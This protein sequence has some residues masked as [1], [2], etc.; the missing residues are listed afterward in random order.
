MAEMN[1]YRKRELQ[2][3]AQEYFS[4]AEKIFSD[5]RIKESR[6]GKKIDT[7]VLE[8]A[9]K[10]IDKGLEIWIN[11]KDAYNLK[12]CIYITLGKTEEAEEALRKAI[13][14][15]PNFYSARYNLALCHLAKGNEKEAQKELV[16][17]IHLKKDYFMAIN[18][19]GNIYQKK[20][21][22]NTAKKLFER[23]INMHEYYIP[24]Y[25]GKA[26]CEEKEGN[27]E[28][29]LKTIKTAIKK[30]PDYK[31]KYSVEGYALKNSGEEEFDFGRKYFEE[32]I[33][34]YP[35]LISLY[36][37]KSIIELKLGKETAAKKSMEK[38][39]STLVFR[40]ID[41]K[42]LADIEK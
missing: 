31:N 37:K 24:S 42:N 11:N 14:I 3:N 34:N 6:E 29:A 16:E 21:E 8:I 19:L 10:L 28:E 12:G 20:E 17:L 13:E 40:K 41:E 35:E 39:K 5:F 23:V 27:L 2:N 33:H 15:D 22:Y 7:K 1:L 38:I 25:I 4:K 18:T 36:Y 32:N 26:N 30:F 9:F